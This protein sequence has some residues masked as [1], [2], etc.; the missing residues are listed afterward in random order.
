MVKAVVPAG[1]RE[2]NSRQPRQD[3]SYYT[4]QGIRVDRPS[5][6]IYIHQGRKIVIK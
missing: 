2:V 3:N 4:L 6:G 5:K 1:I